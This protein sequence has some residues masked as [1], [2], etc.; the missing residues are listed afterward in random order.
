MVLRWNLGEVGRGSAGGRRGDANPNP[1]SSSGY[2]SCG[3]VERIR[4]CTGVENP[5]LS[6]RFSRIVLGR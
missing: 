4:E 6:P 3:A 5:G 1:T 2:L